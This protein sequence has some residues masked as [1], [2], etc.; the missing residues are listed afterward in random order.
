[1]QPLQARVGP[2][3]QP[4]RAEWAFEGNGGSSTPPSEPHLTIARPRSARF[5]ATSRGK[6]AL[7]VL[8]AAL[9]TLVLSPLL[10]SLALAVKLTSRGPV[11]FRQVRLGRG[12]LRFELMKFRTMRSDAEGFLRTHEPLW[13]EYLANNHKLS[14][15]RD[16]RLTRAGR[17]L[18]RWSLDELP[19]LFNVLAGSMSLV[20]PRPIVP[21]EIEQYGDRADVYLTSTPGMTGL[22]QVSGRSLIGY[23]DRIAY[24]EDYVR[25]WS[26]RLDLGILLRTPRAVITGTG[27]H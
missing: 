15:E 22:W 18:R 1:M 11:L 4:L 26:L 2:D 21:T 8:V 25:R 6:R 3:P 16:P 12:G 27:A 17:F 7:D 9:M 23:P 24:D 13:R 19:Q 10:L 20:G 5:A 14:A